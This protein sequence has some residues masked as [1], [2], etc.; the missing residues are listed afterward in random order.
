M[1]NSITITT[2]NIHKG[3]SIFNRTVKMQG[4][5]TALAD[6]QPD[7]LCLQEVQGENQKR[8]KDF[9]DFPKQPHHQWFGEYLDYQH[10]YRENCTYNHGHHGNA[11]LSQH[12]IDTRHNL[13]ISVNPIETRGV[14]HCHVTPVG[15]D[16]HIE[17]LCPHLNLLEYCRRRQYKIIREYIEDTLDPQQPLILAGDLNDWTKVSGNKL[18]K[19]LGLQEAIQDT[20]GQFKATFPAMLPVVSLDRIFV[21]NLSIKGAWVHKGK[22]WAWLSDHLPVSAELAMLH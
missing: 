20:K 19:P 9:A 10:S 5:A 16:T 18:G 15:W 4:M 2:Y 21:R 8:E 17:V 13:N 14:L 11:I 1:K 12:P 7:I 22:P 3:M 6:F